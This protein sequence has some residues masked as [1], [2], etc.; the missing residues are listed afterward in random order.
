MS[1]VIQ[2]AADASSGGITQFVLDTIDALGEV[3]VGFLAAAETLF[4]PIP[5]ELILPL[6]GYLSH[7]G[8]MSFL[9]VMIA[10][11]LGG[12]IGA[13]ILYAF[14]AILGEARAIR[15][16]GMLPLV[17]EEDFIKAADWFHRHGRSAVF[18]GR[19]V[20]L[21]RSLISLPAGAA[22][23]NLWSFTLYTLVG[24]AIWN[25][26]LVGAGYLLGTQHELVEEYMHYIDYVV[27]A[28]IIGVMV[29]LVT[30]RILRSRRAAV[31]AAATPNASPDPADRIESDSVA[32]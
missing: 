3:G 21:V 10:A 28:V 1:I 25:L 20:P 30:R 14:G 27:Y 26:L 12:Y 2:A 23:M 29:W 16:L 7:T 6:A 5:S 19:F 31:I 15:W 8:Q 11:T 32:R 17:D 13:V 22:K 4:P 18:F 9:W 24:S